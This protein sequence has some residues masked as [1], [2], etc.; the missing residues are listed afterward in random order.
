MRSGTFCP[1]MEPREAEPECCVCDFCPGILQGHHDPLG[2]EPYDAATSRSFVQE[3][4]LLRNAEEWVART[5]E[6][7]MDSTVNARKIEAL[8]K[9]FNQPIVLPEDIEIYSMAYSVSTQVES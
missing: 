3:D 4:G 7:E 6:Y 2:G 9:L 1:R 5:F 8:R